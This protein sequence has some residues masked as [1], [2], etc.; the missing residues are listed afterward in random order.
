[1]SEADEVVVFVG[2]GEWC[3]VLVTGALVVTLNS[4]GRN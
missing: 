1:M 3:S 4:N 2:D